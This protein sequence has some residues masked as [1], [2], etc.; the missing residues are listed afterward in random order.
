MSAIIDLPSGAKVE[1]R[2][3][4]GKEAKTLSD[5]D[6]LK[7]GVF[8]ERI[9]NSCMLSV[10]DPSPYT[11]PAGGQF[12]WA[13]ALVGDRFY[14]LLMLRVLTFGEDFLFKVQCSEEMCRER[15][16]YQINLVEDLPVR[17]LS[18]AD[19]AAFAAGNVFETADANGKMIKY[20]LPTGKDE[21]VSAKVAQFDNAFIQSMLQRIVEIE[22]EPIPRKYLED[23]EFGDLLKLLDVFDVHNC[24]VETDIEIECPCC[25]AIQDIKL[26]FARGFLVPTRAK[27]PLKS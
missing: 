12:D 3:L 1:I 19:R 10:V 11:I 13:N 27:T 16:D 23:C 20:R 26:P 25:K 9:L 18:D 22:G 5:K 6:A 21:V 24:G 7:S 4:K 14:G 17:R 2:G 8:L 15:F